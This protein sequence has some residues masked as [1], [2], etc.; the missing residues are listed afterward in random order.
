MKP[1]IYSIIYLAAG[2]IFL[3]RNIIYFQDEEK[4]RSFL[5]KSPKARL[6]LKKLGMDKTIQLSQKIFLP[7]GGAISLG[8]IVAGIFTLLY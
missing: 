4:L 1:Y 2:S 6:W 5:E 7:L 3:I 8:F